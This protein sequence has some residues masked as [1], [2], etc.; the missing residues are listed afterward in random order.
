MMELLMLV[1]ALA[2]A[3]VV[4]VFLA[5]IRKSAP[6]NSQLLTLGSALVVLG[7]VLGEDRLVGYSFIGAGVILSIASVLTNR[8]GSRNWGQTS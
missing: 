8:K 2:T 5:G 1:V 4:I 6:R 3:G 7:I